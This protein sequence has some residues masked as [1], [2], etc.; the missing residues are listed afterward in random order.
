MQKMPL[1]SLCFSLAFSGAAWSVTMADVELADNLTLDGV[2]MPYR[3]AGIRSKFFMDLYVSSL[4]NQESL[5]AGEL[6]EGQT[7]TT[8]QLDIISSMITSEKMTASM[9]DGF[10]QSAG[11]HL[12]QLKE[13]ISQ[14]TQ[15][16]SAPVS[17]GDTFQIVS[18]PGQPVEL[19]KNGTKLVAVEGELFRSVLLGIWLGD[20]PLDDDLKEEMLGL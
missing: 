16:F 5:P 7:A 10:A 2:E 6:M 1:L 11:K 4:Y 14:F 18:I 3:G 17:E 15:A 9:E 12:P 20:D 8:I 13:Q 19:I